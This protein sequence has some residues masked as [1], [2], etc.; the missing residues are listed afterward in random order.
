MSDQTVTVTQ[1][2][3]GVNVQQGFG[4]TPTGGMTTTEGDV[5]YI[6]KADINQPNGIAGLDV[7]A[8]ITPE[9]LPTPLVSFAQLVAN[10]LV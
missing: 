3:Q 6:K 8:Q 10:Q 2:T 7:N 5:R 9:S 1:Q 4:A